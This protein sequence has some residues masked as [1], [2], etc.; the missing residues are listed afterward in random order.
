ME[1]ISPIAIPGP[2]VPMGGSA[3]VVQLLC[4]RFLPALVF[5]AAAG[6]R[7][8]GLLMVVRRGLAGH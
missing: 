1:R 5:A 4:D 6:I 3:P 2:T 8:F 7:G